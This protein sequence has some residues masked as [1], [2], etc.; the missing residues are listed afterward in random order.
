MVHSINV[1][2]PFWKLYIEN[3]FL[4]TRDAC[5][6]PIQNVVNIY[7]RYQIKRVGNELYQ[8][9]QKYYVGSFELTIAQFVQYTVSHLCNIILFHYSEDFISF[10][11]IMQYIE[12]IISSLHVHY[13]VAHIRF[14]FIVQTAFICL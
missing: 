12:D 14:P 4:Q 13:I 11:D 9:K 3:Y 2:A 7:L 8:T 10:D 5:L 6:F 1:N